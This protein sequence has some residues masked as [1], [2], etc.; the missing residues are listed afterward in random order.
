MSPSV[1]TTTRCRSCPRACL[2][3]SIVKI[4]IL[5]GHLRERRWRRW[6]FYDDDDDDDDPSKNNDYNDY[7]DDGVGL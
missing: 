3:F 6:L 2:S 7:N 4:I 5:T 1:T